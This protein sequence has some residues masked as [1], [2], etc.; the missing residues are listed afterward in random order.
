P[1][2]FITGPAKSLF[3]PLAMAVVFAMMTS[4]FLSRTLVPTMVH[5]LLESEV[6]LYGG[7]EEPGMVHDHSDRNKHVG[8]ISSFYWALKATLVLAI[9]AVAIGALLL[10]VPS[11]Q[12]Y[13]PHWLTGLARQLREH[14]NQT[15]ISIGRVIAI[16]IL[17][18]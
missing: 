18:L 2:V 1:V 14:R 8:L 17:S 6:F 12:D 10:R 4:Y 3:T 7:A 5:Y 13:L 15:L 11:L 16:A 9:G